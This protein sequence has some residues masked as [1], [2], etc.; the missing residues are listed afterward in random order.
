M[1][2]EPETLEGTYRVVDE[3]PEA[4]WRHGEPVFHEGGIGRLISLILA[5]SFGA[6]IF[7]TLYNG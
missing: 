1:Q 6:W 2:N 4:P 7:H 3:G 5:I